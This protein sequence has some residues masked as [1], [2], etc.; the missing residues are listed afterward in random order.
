M[1]HIQ[2]DGK[3]RNDIQ[4]GKLVAIVEKH[5]QRFGS[6]T[7]GIV[8]RLLT[9]SSN[10]PHGIKVQLE[11]GKIGRVKSILDAQSK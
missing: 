5:N 4:I 8:K 10:H 6:L 9:K 1:E 7:R 11:S 2:L 3:L